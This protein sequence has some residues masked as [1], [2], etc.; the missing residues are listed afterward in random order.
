MDERVKASFEFAQDATKQLITLATA[1]IALTITFLND[2][3]R[4]APGGTSILIEV[5]WFLYL[6]SIV[7]GIVTLL[8]LTGELASSRSTQPS[9][10]GRDIRWPSALQILAFLAAL[11]LTLIFGIRAV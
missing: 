11:I 2:V 3:I 1:I 7:F 10:Y 4:S 6:A 8:G 9:V 5:A